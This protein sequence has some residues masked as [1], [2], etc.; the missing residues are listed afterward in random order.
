MN[1]GT[2]SKLPEY[3]IAHIGSY[4]EPRELLKHPLRE[5]EGFKLTLRKYLEGKKGSYLIFSAIYENCLDEVEFLLKEGVDPNVKIYRGWTPLHEATWR[6]RTDIVK[7]LLDAGADKDV[8]LEDGMTPV[9]FAA[10]VGHTDILKLLLDTGA[11]EVKNNKSKTQLNYVVTS[12][13]GK[14]KR[15][16]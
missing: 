4:L 14:R 16:S 11:E 5:T 2:L 13:L 9:L 6:G 3:I 15:S 1:L 7:L 8:K 12:V 10:M